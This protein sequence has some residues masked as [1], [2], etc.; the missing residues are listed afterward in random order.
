[1]PPPAEHPGHPQAVADRVP[2]LGE[3]RFGKVDQHRSHPALDEILR[4]ADAHDARPDYSNRLE[5]FHL[6]S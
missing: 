2:C 1:M 4:H 6:H 5:C 3:N